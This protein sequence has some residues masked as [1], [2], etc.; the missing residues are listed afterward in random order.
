[1]PFEL[2]EVTSDSEFKPLIEAEWDS[3]EHPYTRILNTFFPIK[4]NTPEAH[5]ERIADSRNRQLEEHRKSPASHWFKVI[6]T[7]TQEIV[8]GAQWFVFEENPYA[9]SEGE[10]H[11]ITWWPVGEDREFVTA[12]MAQFVQARMTYMQKPH[13][14]M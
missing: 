7:E 6:D 14:R 9:T 11:E 12:L 4:G 8:G 13:M 5:A 1:M 2:L 10:D 3:Y